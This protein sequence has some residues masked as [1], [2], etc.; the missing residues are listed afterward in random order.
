MTFLAMLTF[1]RFWTSEKVIDFRA[2]P[3]GETFIWDGSDD[4][5]KVVEHQLAG[6]RV[7]WMMIQKFG[8]VITLA[9]AH[10]NE[11]GGRLIISNRAFDQSF[12]HW[13]ESQ[14]IVGPMRPTHHPYSHHASE[15]LR[16]SMLFQKVDHCGLTCGIICMLDR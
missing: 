7:I 15:T 11:E 5:I 10:V 14:S 6:E 16:L 3:R 13:I 1:Y 9:A 4:L 12:L 8:E 2:N